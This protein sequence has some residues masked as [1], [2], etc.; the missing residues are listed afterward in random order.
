MKKENRIQK[1]LKH[2]VFWLL[3]IVFVF[4]FVGIAFNE[5]YGCN[6]G[7]LINITPASKVFLTVWTTAFGVIG[8]II[9]LIINSNRL[10]NQ[11]E[12]LSLQ[13]KS[14]RNSRFSKAIEL[15]G[16]NHESAR[17]GAVHT[18]YSLAK[19][20]KKEYK[21][22]VFNILCSHIRTTTYTKE[23]QEI[24]L[25]KPSNEI[26]TIIEILF[27]KEQNNNSFFDGLEADLNG[28]F[29]RGL[30]L[31][32]AALNGANLKDVVLFNAKLFNVDFIK[33]N[34]FNSNL[35]TKMLTDC[36]FQS[37]VIRKSRFEGSM[38]NRCHFE[39]SFIHGSHFEQTLMSS[40]HFEGATI[41]Q[42]HFEGANIDDVHFEGSNISTSLF[43]CSEISKTHFNGALINQNV[44]FSGAT[45]NET[46]FDGAYLNQVYFEGCEIK[47]TSILGGGHFEF[48]AEDRSQ[49]NSDKTFLLTKQKNKG[50]VISDTLHFGLLNLEVTRFLDKRM[51]EG[52]VQDDI[53]EKI[54]A[55]LSAKQR[56]KSKQDDFTQG[57]LD[58]DIA[59]QFIRIIKKAEIKCNGWRQNQK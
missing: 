4:P 36:N 17:I 18:L 40:L 21:E 14:E 19:E 9:N 50:T 26:Q 25:K 29:L 51:K 46:T 23:Y 7:D 56:I 3:L 39:N 43:I 5:W 41:S 31:H 12:Q 8:L 48:S 27:R 38:L 34:F 52:K 42:T 13:S 54:Y 47:Q 44:R 32:N 11:E 53:I 1:L 37:S 35:R 15:L 28:S 6:W 33:T 16:N 57:L 45:I 55:I 30:F 59:E 24:Y 10:T 58:V 49:F 2:K 22:L 20:Y